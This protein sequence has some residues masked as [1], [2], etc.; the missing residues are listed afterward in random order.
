MSENNDSPIVTWHTPRKMTF[1]LFGLEPWAIVVDKPSQKKQDKM[2]CLWNNNKWKL[3]LP[4]KSMWRISLPIGVRLPSRIPVCLIWLF[5][6]YESSASWLTNFHL[7]K[8]P[9]RKTPLLLRLIPKEG[10]RNL[11]NQFLHGLTSHCFWLN[12]IPPSQSLQ[13][14]ALCLSANCPPLTSR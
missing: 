10:E 13:A 1:E 7:K 9:H 14:T 12:G 2:S 6:F 4:R 3:T 11:W 5:C 8:S